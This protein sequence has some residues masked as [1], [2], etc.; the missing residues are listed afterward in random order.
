MNKTLQL[1][2][3]RVAPL[4][5]S[6][7]DKLQHVGVPVSVVTLAVFI[8]TFINIEIMNLMQ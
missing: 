6:F 2:C 4:E 1:D 7:L 3:C 5:K 8:D